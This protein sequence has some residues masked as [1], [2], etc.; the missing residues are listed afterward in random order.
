MKYIASI[1]ISLCSVMPL[2]AKIDMDKYHREI[3]EMTV[4]EN[5]SHPEVPKKFI[6]AVNTHMAILGGQF[7]SL[8]RVD[9]NLTERSGMVLMLTI[10][11]SEFFAPNDTVVRTEGIKYLQEIAKHMSVPDQYKLLVTVHSD[12]TGSEEYLS[13]LTRIRSEAI[14]TKFAE[15]GINTKGIVPYGM[16]YDEPLNTEQTRAG[17]AANRRVEF[18][19]IPG[20]TLIEGLK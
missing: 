15:L 19:I 17:R 11:V 10:P 7:M 2:S 20:P 6:P 8:D 14:V 12:D 9:V 4:D 16:G 3:L 18:Y 13:D 1:I 5:I